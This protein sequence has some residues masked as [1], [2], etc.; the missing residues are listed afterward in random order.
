MKLRKVVENTTTDYAGNYI[1]E[2]NDLQFFNH[3]EGYVK[4]VIASGSAAIS[5]FEYVYQYKDHLGNVRLCYTDANK[6]GVITAST[7]IIEESNYYPFGL[8][9]RGYNNVT[10]S[11]GN[12][13]AQKFGYNGKELNEEL[14]FN[15]YDYGARMY[16]PSVGRWFVIDALA[17]DPMQID[18]T[19]YNFTWNNPVNIDDPD[20]N[21][22]W[23]IWGAV[24]GAG[25][26]YGS[27]VISNKIQGKSWSESLT[28]VDGK[29]ILFSAATGA[30]SGGIGSIKTLHTTGK[31]YKTLGGVYT[32]GTGSIIKQNIGDDATGK[33]DVKTVAIDIG[34]KVVKVPKVKLPGVNKTKINVSKAKVKV[35]RAEAVRK[36]TANRQKAIKA[37]KKN[38]KKA[39]QQKQTI[40]VVDKVV[41][42]IQ[43]KIHKKIVQKGVDKTMEITN[44]NQ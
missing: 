6:D 25:L 26:E 32:A 39:E 12:S 31:I 20:G 37:A 44:N 21:C 11:L 2:D 1:Y 9:Q 38:L 36:G 27:Q 30:I 3:P 41:D 33:V 35:K 15:M 23:C 29:K 40:D 34:M 19:P 5:S 16:D 8:R 28:Q 22:P 24:I 42:K 17:D 18:L 13:V 10:N 43:G 4:T 7:E 14:G